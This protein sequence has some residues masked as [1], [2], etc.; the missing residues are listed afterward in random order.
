[1]STKKERVKM[2][3]IADRA[4]VSLSTVSRV[5]NKTAVVSEEHR[6]AVEKAV[7]ELN[8][9]QNP[10]A[11][12]LSSGK[13]WTVGVLTQNFG[14]PFY[15]TLMRGILQGL[16]D[17]QYSPIFADGRWQADIEENALQ[18]LHDRQVDGVIIIGGQLPAEKVVELDIPFV[19]I[20]RHLPQLKNHCITVDNATAAYQATRYL[21]E[22]GHRNIAHFT[23]PRPTPTWVDDI[24]QRREGYRK[25]LEEAGIGYDP[26][27]VVE[28]DLRQQSGMQSLEMLLMRGR[29][30]SAI[31]AANDQMALGARLGLHRRGWRVPDDVSLVGFDDLGGTAYAIPPLTTV[32]QPAIEMGKYAA[33]SLLAQVKGEAAQSRCFSAELIIRESVQR[34][35]L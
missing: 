25:A 21:I 14:T 15:D 24:Q 5:L 9:R 29:S 1:M 16:E 18:L 17:T 31:F 19:L 34:Y 3:D 30:F 32:H 13:S 35:I 2:K 20:A 8:Y 4:N 11:R 22:M 28:G 10:L 33:E 27:L 26:Q 12:A 7:A 6:V 23:A